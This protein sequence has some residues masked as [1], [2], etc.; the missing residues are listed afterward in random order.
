MNTA[1]IDEILSGS[2]NSVDTSA[3]LGTSTE[4]A[5]TQ[6]A[7]SELTIVSK[8]DLSNT[9]NDPIYHFSL[10]YPAGLKVSTFPNAD[11]AGDYV[12]IAD[13]KT[14]IGMQIFISPFD[15]PASALT[16]DRIKKD[17]PSLAVINPQPLSGKE[18]GSGISFLDGD[19]TKANRQVWFV[20]G[21]NLYQ[22][23]AP[24]GFDA[25]LGKILATMK[26]GK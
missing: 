19:D 23:T 1:S 14:G 2:P 17:A 20:A 8:A 16:A 15:E 13:N 4:S 18:L 11:G 21:G 25:T 9:Y 7:S 26:M 12:L 10:N 24:K 3:P 6:A 5:S 22:I